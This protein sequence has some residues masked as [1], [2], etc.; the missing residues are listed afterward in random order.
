MQKNVPKS[1]P[2]FVATLRVWA[3]TSKR[4]V[5]YAL[6]NDRRTLLWFAN[7]RAVE[8]HPTLVRAGQPDRVGHISV[9][10]ER[11]ALSDLMPWRA[12]GRM[13]DEELTAVFEY[14]RSRNLA[15]FVPG[16]LPNPQ[17]ELIILLP[18]A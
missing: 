13:D 10:S 1:T 16:D 8:L 15:A 4:E 2:D 6:C 9:P 11:R 14:L 18:E 12:L 17:L 7:Q 5:T 3:E